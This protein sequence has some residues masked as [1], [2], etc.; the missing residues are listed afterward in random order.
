MLFHSFD[1]L[2]IFLPIVLFGYFLIKNNKYR[3]L[4]LILASFIFYGWGNV[5]WVFLL[6][7]AATIDFLLAKKISLCHQ[8]N[9]AKID[10][11]I[12]NKPAI[13][14][15][16]SIIFNISL[17]A[18]FKYWDWLVEII[19]N[20]SSL[21][22]DDFKHNI[23]FP[24]AISFYT[25][26]T[27]SYTID[28]YRK[29][30]KANNN[31]IEYLGFIAFFP[32]LVA[33]PIQRAN[34][35]IPQL[36]KLRNFISPRSFDYAIFLICWGLCK[37]LV[38]AD[39]LGIIIEQ[40]HHYINRPGM[41]FLLAWSF[42]FQLYCD[43]SAY[44]DI[45]RGVAKLFN[46]N[47]SRNFLTPYLASNPRDFFRR[48]NITLSNWVKDYIYIPLGGNKSGKIRQIFLLYLTMMIIGLWHGASIFFL[49]YGV[50]FATISLFYIIFPIDKICLKIFGKNIGRILAILLGSI[51]VP[52][53]MILFW[54]KNFA[55]FKDISSSFFAIFKIIG[56]NISLISTEFAMISYGM[57]LFILPILI[58]DI[59]GYR[60]NKEFVE[61]YPA[62]KLPTKI[63]LYLIIFYLIIFFASR[64]SYKFIYFQF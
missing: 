4:F 22:L 9:P 36:A 29:K 18:F 51:F 17:L 40:S 39:N 64:G 48:W 28:I 44:I 15:S 46:I 16:I 34:E 45:A 35:L 13:L 55:D 62:F 30:F 26:E 41:G 7:I 43:F 23:A 56:G 19:A 14:L 3:N 11:E 54:T 60:K 42:A 20:L 6:I 24:A 31:F 10:D 59:I 37:K 2:L 5:F 32:K 27:L 25:F 33:G 38:F 1:F 52:F 12:S 57:I 63:A 61:L 50:Y 8:K 53:G 47:L 49:L 58:T 21:F